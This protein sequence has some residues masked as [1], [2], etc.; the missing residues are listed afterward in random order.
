MLTEAS[1]S[2]DIPVT[3]TLD[4]TAQFTN[5]IPVTIEF[6]NRP[7][8]LTNATLGED[9]TANTV[10][11][12]IPAGGASVTA[13]ITI[14]PVEDS[15]AEDDEIA[16]LVA[17]STALTGSDGMGITIQDNDTEPDQV[18]LTVS[19]DT[20]YETSGSTPLNVTAS[21]VGQ[22]FRRVDTVVTV[23][24]GSGTA[25]LGEDFESATLTLTIPTGEMSTAGTLVFTVTDDT[26]HEGDETL[27]I[28]AASWA[29]PSPLLT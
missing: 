14:T 15:I 5:D 18:V 16:R 27:H 9:F 1:G 11:T 24:P 23:T 12:V 29:W 2:V 4:G 3:V 25:T 22:A 8:V 13:T 6:V 20:L 28:S 21:L 10:N 7:N 19:P 17:K 26:I